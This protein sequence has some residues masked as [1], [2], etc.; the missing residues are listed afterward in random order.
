M[1]R[2][3]AGARGYG[4][5]SSATTES[6]MPSP[7]PQQTSDQT[8]DGTRAPALRR[9][10]WREPFA[11]MREDIDRMFAAFD[12]LGMMPERWGRNAALGAMAGWRASD[13]PACELIETE[14]G[15]E[16]RAEV[17]GY[18]PEDL[19]LRLS[20]G[21]LV[22]KGGRAAEAEG[23]DEGL[24]WSER[25]RGSFR[26][27]FRLPPAADPAHASA[28]IRAGVLHVMLPRRAGA[29]PGANAIPIT[30]D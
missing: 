26:R 25:S 1:S 27:A 11:S 29:A 5:R 10:D 20:D 7:S 3:A 8:R 18:A 9:D 22:L 2:R 19:D 17:P 28:E 21:M 15:F 13:L 23:T 6:T 30:A 12:P 14:A 4:E 24:H 16:L